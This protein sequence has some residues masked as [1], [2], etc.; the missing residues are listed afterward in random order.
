MIS[1]LAQTAP[2]AAA[3]QEEIYFFVAIGLLGLAII[4]LV[5]ELFVP[6]AG[7]LAVMTGVSAVGSVASMFVYDVTWGGV[8]LAVLCAGSPIVLL[9][10]FKIWSKTPIAHRMIL[11]EDA[12]GNKR[13]AD[14]GDDESANTSVAT[15]GSAA[16]TMARQLATFVTRPPARKCASI[17][18]V[19]ISS[20]VFFALIRLSTMSDGFT[21]LRRIMMRSSKLTGA[22]LSQ[23]SNH[24]CTDC[25]MMSRKISPTTA[26]TASPIH[27]QGSIAR[28]SVELFIV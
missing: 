12:D 10:V 25:P 14:D 6:S 21:F 26:M 8:Y 22:P 4:L 24:S 15:S 17:L 2:A 3:G 5:L 9:L 7:A 28:K 20:P 16:K 11:K 18:W 19:L 23:A 13:T 1:F 27:A